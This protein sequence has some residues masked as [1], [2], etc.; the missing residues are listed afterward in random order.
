MFQ[1]KLNVSILLLILLTIV[2]HEVKFYIY[3]IL[4]L[5]WF[6]IVLQS[7]LRILK[8]FR[9]LLGTIIYNIIIINEISYASYITRD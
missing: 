9:V 5:I 2:I 8:I 1:K 7:I 3:S 4:F 6:Y